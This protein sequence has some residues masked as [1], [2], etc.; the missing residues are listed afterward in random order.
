MA[1]IAALH[2]PETAVLDYRA[3]C[4][5]LVRRLRERGARLLPGA[6]LVGGADRGAAVVLETTRGDVAADVAVACA[7]LH[8]DVV[9]RL[10][11]HG[12]SV[13]IVPFRGEYREIRPPAAHLVRGLVYPVPDPHSPS[14]ACT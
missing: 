10:L 14:S 4:R 3:V 2:V 9:A 5:V 12:P 8:A 11:G 13:R 6:E 1:A 7:G